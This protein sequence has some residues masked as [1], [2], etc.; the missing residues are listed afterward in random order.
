[1]QIF[2]PLSIGHSLLLLPAC[3]WT[4]EGGQRY[5]DDDEARG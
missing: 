1:M 3:A 2:K 5:S 4:A